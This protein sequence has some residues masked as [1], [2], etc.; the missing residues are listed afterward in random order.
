MIHNYNINIK[1]SIQQINKVLEEE[2]TLNPQSLT[3]V[4]HPLCTF[5]FLDQYD[6]PRSNR[7]PRVR[8]IPHWSVR[9]KEN[10]L[11]KKKTF[12]DE[13]SA[14]SFYETIYKTIHNI[15]RYNREQNIH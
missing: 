3:D 1:E 13:E 6:Y 10:G 12:N 11:W 9:Y 5:L 2:Y 15:T 7:R 14:F 8:A 4:H